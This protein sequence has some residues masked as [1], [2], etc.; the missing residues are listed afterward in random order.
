MNI[1]Y[2][3]VSI[4]ILSAHLNIPRETLI[5][6]LE[7]YPCEHVK[8]YLPIL[9]KDEARDIRKIFPSGGGIATKP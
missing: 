6:L 1:R 4:K 7:N 5:H 3:A 9:T 8:T 2:V